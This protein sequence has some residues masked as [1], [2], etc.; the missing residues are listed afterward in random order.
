MNLH[1]HVSSAGRRVHEAGL[2]LVLIALALVLLLIV[3]PAGIAVNVSVSASPGTPRLVP[4]LAVSGI[5][6]ALLY[7]LFEMLRNRPPIHDPLAQS[8]GPEAGVAPSLDRTWRAALVCLACLLCAFWG[9]FWIGFY[10]GS[11]IL[12]V[13]VKLLLGERRFLQLLVIPV[14]TVA[15]IYLLFEA[16]FQVR[17]P[18]PALMAVEPENP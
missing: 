12:M 7:G 4:Q 13:V 6:S 16:G 11:V 18:Q 17:M 15:C 3:I 9:F 2:A 8:T 5:I 1:G 10:A 14:L